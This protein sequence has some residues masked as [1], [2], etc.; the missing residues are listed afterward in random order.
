MTNHHHILPHK[1][2]LVKGFIP[3]VT[4]K[5]KILVYLYWL[6]NKL[7]VF[8]Y[9]PGIL[10]TIKLHPSSLLTFIPAHLEIFPEK[11]AIKYCLFILLLVTLKNMN[12]RQSSLYNSNGFSVFFKLHEAMKLKCFSAAEQ[13]LMICQVVTGAGW[14]FS[15]KVVFSLVY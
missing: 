14:N 11:P 10:K 12:L 9:H 15:F 1:L 4:E 8:F 2:C 13:L 3:N 7:Q 6:A 5:V